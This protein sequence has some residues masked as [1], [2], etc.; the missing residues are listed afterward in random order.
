MR[1]AW[2]RATS[3]LL[4]A[5]MT[6]SLLSG[7]AALAKELA[8]TTTFPE[9]YTKYEVDP[10]SG[11]WSGKDYI[12]EGLMMTDEEIDTAI[13]AL[14]NTMT[15]DEKMSYLGGKGQGTVYGNA[16]DLPGTARLG[17]PEMR[18][19]DGPAGVM[20]LW[21]TT[22]TP[23]RQMT[24]ATWDDELVE[25][26][27]KVYGSEG[28]A[29]GENMQ[30]GSQYDI[31]R[32]P[33]FGRA[34]D[35]YGEDPYLL[36]RLAVA[37]TKG[38]QGE[39]IIAV[40]KHFA[41]FA[42][43]ASP[44]G[45][46]DVNIS[47]QAL[48][49]LYLPAFEAAIQEGGMLGLMSSYNA[50]NGTFA[51]SNTNLQLDVL[52]DLWGYK[53][54]TI[55]D[56]GGNDGFTLN[57]GTDIEMPNLS[58]NKLEKVQEEIEDED[59]QMAVIDNAVGHVLYA[60]GHA[61]YLAL[62]ETYTDADGVLKAKVDPSKGEG[63]RIKLYADSATAVEA[64]QPENNK[65]VQDVAEGGGVLLKNEDKTLPIAQDGSESLAV[66]G[67]GGKYTLAGTGGERS[68]GVGYLMTSPYEALKGILGEENVSL[69]PVFDGGGS[70]IPA[71]N[72]YYKDGNGEFQQGF[73]LANNG[74]T[75]NVTGKPI[76]YLPDE[77]SFFGGTAIANQGNSIQDHGGTENQEEN[78]YIWTTYIQA[79][80]DG[81]YT[82]VLHGL[83]GKISAKVSKIDSVKEDELATAPP[84]SSEPVKPSESTPPTDSPAET[85]S[86]EQTDPPAQEPAA[87]PADADV[88]EIV[89][90]EE[91]TDDEA[92]ADV[93][94]EQ[95][96]DEADANAI[97]E[98]ADGEIVANEA[99][100]QADSK[101]DANA[102]DEQ[103]D[104]EIDATVNDEQT[105][106][107]TDATVNDE[108]TDGETDADEPS[109]T[110]VSVEPADF[111]P[112]T[113]GDWGGGGSQEPADPNVGSISPGYSTTQGIQWHS[114]DYCTDSG[115]GISSGVTVTMEEGKY[116]K[117]EIT[118]IAN[119]VDKD[120][121]LRLAW[122][123]P[124]TSAKYDQKTGISGGAYENAIQLA[125][126]N[127]KVVVFVKAT[128]GDKPDT[129]DENNLN[130]S[131]DQEKL[132]LDVADAAH[133]AGN[134]VIVVI[135]NETAV[136]IHNWVDEVDAVL[137]MYKPGQKGGEATANLLTGV[138]NP[139]GKLAYA[140][141]MEG[142][143]TLITHTDEAFEKQEHA[144]LT[145][146][147]ITVKT[148]ITMYE[149]ELKRIYE[150][151]QMDVRM[152]VS[153]DINTYELF[154]AAL[155]KEDA[156]SEK[157]AEVVNKKVNGGTVSDYDEGILTGYRFYD[158]QNIKP[159]YD[160]GYGLSY[161]TF[162]YTGLSVKE[163]AAEGEKVGYDVSFTVTNT[164][165]VAGREVAQLYLGEAKNLP[166]GIQS[167]PV[168]LAG[169][170]KTK[171][172]A[173][174]ASEDITLHVDQRALSYWNQN[175]TGSTVDKWTIAEGDRTI[176]VGSSS[177]D[178]LLSQKVTVDDP[179]NNGGGS[180]GGG[181]GSSSSGSSTTTTKNDDGS[182]TKTVTD[183]KT[184]TV[185]ETTTYTDG[186]KKVVETKTDGTVTATLT[187]KDG[188]KT[189]S[190]TDK[191]GATTATVT[192]PDGVDSAKVT[193]PVSAKTGPGT[194]AVLVKA[195]GTEEVI[196]NSVATQGGVVVTVTGDAKLK[197]VDNSKTFSDTASGDWFADAVAFATAH[198][199]FQGTGDDTFSPNAPMTRAMLV[200]VLH[201][202]E[203]APAG[204]TLAFDDVADGTWYS[205]AVAWAAENGIVTGTEKGFEPDGSITRESLAVILYR[206]AKGTAQAG[207]L[208]DYA[209]AGIVSG[210]AKD[211]M[212]WAVAQGL[213]SG[214]DGGALDPAG[215]ASRAEVATI[216]MR[217]L[218]N[219]AK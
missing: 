143:Q 113:G 12:A 70:A 160:F 68:Y 40:G 177:D 146:E 14:L 161:T 144:D 109:E 95:T 145:A 67:L 201:R 81:D 186:T 212:S 49:E 101:A 99:D 174:G 136:T 202:Y 69:E 39:G 38:M 2:K 56:W 193:I 187:Q 206:Y 87:A 88:Q 178:L 213:I 31:T 61:G 64:L 151:V 65:I 159:R 176:Y 13:E 192:L 197:I 66:I 77:D 111:G 33:E 10:G 121:Q 195:D 125:K 60:L 189:E 43:A 120:M 129:R 130:I 209:D 47:E 62:V 162:K 100:E 79:P 208:D 175:V 96:G 27:G 55:T 30:L 185:T 41:A 5:S 153:Q 72:L 20:S 166:K 122:L 128:A 78:T 183:K 28:K 73:V 179:S 181:G 17:V 1:R 154:K 210:W 219:Q 75:E 3:I 131:A 48:H 194:V 25:Q 97:D 59:E 163:S 32:T 171:E 207:A 34:K 156:T 142:N 119:R 200:T 24:A 148:L 91:Q 116:Y 165:D 110:D 205:D 118:G 74:E 105:D 150:R 51:S 11:K 173:P 36:S 90:P 9:Y 50:I 214:K 44:A 16:A 23:N 19:H 117:V 83:G 138:V 57:K 46:T 133:E 188:T 124:N 15:T 157:I 29:I 4:T 86:V 84:E 180:S 172:L 107:E 158:S 54:F 149:N 139:S 76:E 18:M 22:N 82:L 217:F 164:G 6:V 115:M 182:T 37:E 126:D 191:S 137:M 26:Y 169:Y 103:T 211:A 123:T 45:K 140:M 190:V 80:A 215:S 132:I 94:D 203:N 71:E 134:E 7:T 152:Q 155:L 135:N 8:T 35:Q 127:D 216:L 63:N 112:P 218:Q 196:K 52:R 58:N 53:G 85:D 106:G 21:P 114:G 89:V 170:T 102:I 168:Q 98:Q 141:P 108:Q 199:L 92:D 184:G 42:Q 198:E 167:A 204:G 104:N 147:K 93:T